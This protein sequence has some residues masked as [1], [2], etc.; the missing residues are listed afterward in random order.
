MSEPEKK[1]PFKCCHCGGENHI[2][3]S[4]VMPPSQRMVFAITHEHPL[5]SLKTIHGTLAG[6]EKL[7]KAQARDLG[8]VCHVFLEG[9]EW[10]P[11]EVRFKLFLADHDVKKRDKAAARAATPKAAA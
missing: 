7:L 6:I 2:R 1:M 3:A 11:N 9:V 8:A 10:E 4:V 5:L